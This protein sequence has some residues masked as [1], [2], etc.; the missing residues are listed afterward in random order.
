MQTFFDPL[1]SSASE[2]ID[3]PTLLDDLKLDYTFTQYPFDNSNYAQ[4]NDIEK[5]LNLNF[6]DGEDNNKQDVECFCDENFLNSKDVHFNTKDDS[7]F[8]LSAL[9]DIPWI[10][11]I[12][13]DDITQRIPE[14]KDIFEEEGLSDIYINF[15][16][17]TLLNE[18]T[19]TPNDVAQ[20]TGQLNRELHE[21]DNYVFDINVPESHEKESALPYASNFTN[22]PHF[23]ESSFT[24]P[25]TPRLSPSVGSELKELLVLDSK[26]PVMMPVKEGNTSLDNMTS[27]QFV[28]NSKLSEKALYTGNFNMHSA[29]NLSKS[30]TPSA[31]F[32]KKRSFQDFSNGDMNMSSLSSPKRNKN[33]YPIENNLDGHMFN[34]VIHDNSLISLPQSHISSESAFMFDNNALSFKNYGW[35]ANGKQEYIDTSSLIPYEVYLPDT[36][37][38]LSSKQV[39]P[40]SLTSIKADLPKNIN[41]KDI[42][43]TTST[44]YKKK[45][46]PV[47]FG[48]FI[49]F[50]ERDAEIILNG[51]APSGSSKKH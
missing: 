51:V 1:C 6:D 29:D 22:T 36:T 30:H 39:N 31:L 16:E 28:N 42:L 21:D 38:L 20:E 40:T 48:S 25:L 35:T 10:K 5:F 8:Q 19:D 49:N 2:F 34:P 46:Y 23:S 24:C 27:K 50:T 37:A 15:D 47:A 13:N 17:S 9:Y 12:F 26:P 43:R 32:T 45:R 11:S 41:M 14:K 4:V 44:K 18:I 33:T 7:G 3:S